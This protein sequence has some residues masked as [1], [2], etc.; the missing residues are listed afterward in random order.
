MQ[1]GQLP[2]E[3]GA[4][5]THETLGDNDLVRETDQDQCEGGG[6]LEVRVLTDGRGGGVK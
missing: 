3:T 5:E 2:A 6:P 4:A 1:S